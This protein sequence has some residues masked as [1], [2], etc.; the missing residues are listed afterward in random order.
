MLLLTKMAAVPFDP[1]LIEAQIALE[2]IP[3][4]N[5]PKIAWDALESGF[6]GPAIR[7]LAALDFP[8]FFEIAEVLP[9]VM[10]ELGVSR[11]SVV[12]A[13]ERLSRITAQ[14]ILASGDDPLK[15]LRDFESLWFR[16]NY[17]KSLASLGTLH[18][19]V[20]V[21]QIQGQSDIEIR[22]W[23]TKTIAEFVRSQAELP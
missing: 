13:A 23:V 19:D 14:R 9:R 20:W 15:H 17:A 6:D 1:R 2:L 10:D 12:Q 7:R 22:K 4:E 21:A 3:S 16:A 11:I 18:D 5:M 8:T